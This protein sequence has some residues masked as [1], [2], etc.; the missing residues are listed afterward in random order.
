MWQRRKTEGKNKLS[1]LF[2]HHKVYTILIAII[3]IFGPKKF[4]ISSEIYG[5][6]PEKNLFPDPE[7]A[8]KKKKYPEFGSATGFVTGGG[9]GGGVRV[10]RRRILD[11]IVHNTGYGQWNIFSGSLDAFV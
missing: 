2:C 3:S 11:H 9:G 10:Q 7:S 4:K 1:Y 5:L 8:M 6:D